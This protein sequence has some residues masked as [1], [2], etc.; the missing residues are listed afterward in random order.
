MPRTYGAGT[1][2]LVSYVGAS[3]GS[4]ASGTLSQ[5][6]RS[7]RAAIL[8]FL[9][10]T[11]LVTGAFLLLDD[12]PRWLFYA[13]CSALGFGV[14]YWAVFV[15]VAAEQFGTDLRATVATAAPNLVRGS[16]V[17]FTLAYAALGPRFGLA[18]SGV[19]LMAATLALALAATWTLRETYG[20]DLDY[21]ESEA[22]AI[23][24]GRIE[25]PAS[26]LTT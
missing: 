15:Q 9:D 22:A 21:T 25:A 16:V 4:L 1:A 13:A 2:V 5:L 14:G 12:A 6:L 7:R 26:S 20:V 18:A 8:I 19:L 23:E 3:A 24:A 10:F 17:P 11:A